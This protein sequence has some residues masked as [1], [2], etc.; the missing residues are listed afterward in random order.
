VAFSALGIGRYSVGQEVVVS[1]V[2]T[3]RRDPCGRVED[4]V[5][6]LPELDSRKPT[7]HC[8]ISTRGK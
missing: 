2:L 6:C 7:A 5:L 1:E 4:L 8:R 3:E